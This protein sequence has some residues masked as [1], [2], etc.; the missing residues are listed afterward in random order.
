MQELLARVVVTQN[1]QELA[2][3]I[4]NYKFWGQL[5]E[6]DTSV[7]WFA[8]EKRRVFHKEQL[9]IL[10]MTVNE[11]AEYL[12]TNAKYSENQQLV[13]YAQQVQAA[14]IAA[15]K[16]Q[17]F[18]LPLQILKSMAYQE[19]IYL[20]KHILDHNIEYS[21]HIERNALLRQ[22][23]ITQQRSEISNMNI[24]QLRE[25]ILQISREISIMQARFDPC[26]EYV[27]ILQECYQLAVEGYAR[28]SPN[29]FTQRYLT[30]ISAK[31]GMPIEKIN[32]VI[33]KLSNI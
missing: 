31:A 24:N 3:I 8:V 21:I 1:L 11:R 25:L 6:H 19:N 16:E 4:H 27:S 32:K 22:A 33:G 18:D 14:V 13:A 20:E 15:N 2:S 17:N 9:R 28:V 29:E 12:I 23:I 30:S 10:N 26:C 7:V 5:N